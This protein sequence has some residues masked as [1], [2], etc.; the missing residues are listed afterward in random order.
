[1]QQ[2]VRP[3]SIG[4]AENHGLSVYAVAGNVGH[5]CSL[6]RA[7]PETK[8]A[9]RTPFGTPTLVVQNFLHAAIRPRF[10]SP[11]H[12]TKAGEES[13]RLA[14]TAN[15]ERAAHYLE[16]AWLVGIHL[17][18]CL[19]SRRVRAKLRVNANHFSLRVGR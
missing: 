9:G 19:R 11:L 8:L 18:F 5:D 4:M 16:L 12:A 14:A 2:P 15:L 10:L 7:T 13:D 3:G 1:A 6:D 17:H